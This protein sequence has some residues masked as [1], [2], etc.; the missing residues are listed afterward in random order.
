MKTVRKELMSKTQPNVTIYSTPSC[1]FCVM[2]KDYL[3]EHKIKYT[4]IDVSQDQKKAQEMMDKSG[5]MGVPV[6]IIQTPNSNIKEEVL[7]G[8][9][10]ARIDKLLG[11]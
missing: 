2:L 1:H 6:T 3:D 5:Q 8:F 7:V 9:D 11:L 4:N 10:K